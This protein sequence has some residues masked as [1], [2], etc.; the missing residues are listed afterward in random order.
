LSK[1]GFAGAPGEAGINDARL[2]EIMSELLA[3]A[4]IRATSK[5]KPEEV[6]L[7]FGLKLPAVNG[8]HRRAPCALVRRP[9]KSTPEMKPL[10]VL[11]DGTVAE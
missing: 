7:A 8:V 10:P 5:W 9:L 4:W 2:F 6:P 3:E 11:T 1:G